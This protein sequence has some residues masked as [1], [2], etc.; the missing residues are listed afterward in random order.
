[1]NIPINLVYLISLLPFCLIWIIL[2]VKGKHTRREMLVMSF[3]IG[4]I[5]L[6]SS[7]Y[8]WTRDWWLP[9]N[10]T[11]TK[12][13]IEDFIMG[14][15]AGG[16]MTTAYEVFFLKRY[17]EVKRKIKMP[18]FL[19]IMLILALI[20]A[21]LVWGIGTT[22]FIASTISMILVSGIIYYFRKDLL[23]NGL[24]SGVLMLVISLLFYYTIIFIFPNWI[25]QTYIFNTLSG[26]KLTGIPI[27]ELIFWFLSGLVWG[28]IYE[29]W[30]YEQLKD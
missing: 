30:H 16:I 19:T 26:I 28:P 11:G 2:F 7:Y 4:F 23:I 1:M 6:V 18:S 27:E 21:W 29:Y 20:T 8:W 13:G 17:L 12:I 15:T 3:I 9:H 14:F 24:W 25:N 22:T 10:I 5:S